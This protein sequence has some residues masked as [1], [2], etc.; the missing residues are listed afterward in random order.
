MK[1]AKGRRGKGVSRERGKRQDGRLHG[2]KEAT[3]H[4]E[5]PGRSTAPFTFLDHP[6]D[7]GFLAR[8][9]DLPQLFAHA[10]LALSDCGWE[11]KRVRPASGISLRVRAANLEDLLYS[12]L[13]EIL[14]FSDAEGWV[15]KRFRVER[16]AQTAEKAEKEAPLLW[17]IIGRAEGEKFQEGRHRARTYIKAVTYH[18]LRVEQRGR[19][20]Q[21]Q[22]YLDV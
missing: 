17:E 3:R 8:G 19:G 7:V 1:Q 14:F 16:V 13:S 18:Q 5:P 12:W 21:A 22:V 2:R 11:L 4:L 15:F 6:A 20:W 9:R 10:A